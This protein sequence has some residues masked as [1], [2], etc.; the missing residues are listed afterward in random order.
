MDLE[1]KANEVK[2]LFQQ[3]GVHDKIYICVANVASL[4]TS[5]IHRKGAPGWS[6]NLVDSSG[7]PMLSLE[8]QARIEETVGSA[9]WIG[10]LLLK[11]GVQTGGAEGSLFEPSEASKALPLTGDDISLDRMFHGFIAKTQEI[12]EYWAKFGRD[13]GYI[14]KIY[15]REIPIKIG[16]YPPLILKSKSLVVLLVAL[17]DSIRV[18]LALSPFDTSLN[19]TVL[20]LLVA[21]EELATGQWRQCILTSLGLISPSGVAAGVVLKYM[22]NVWLLLNPDIRSDIILVSYKASKSLVVG[23]L[24]WAATVLPPVF[25]QKQTEE[26]LQK[27]RDLVAPMQKQI[28]DVKQKASQL[29]EPQ[30]L[31][32][33]VKGV[34]AE[35]LANISVDDIQILQQL[36]QN[37]VLVCSKEAC[38]IIDKIGKDPI[39]RLVVELCG[40]PIVKEDR[41]EVCGSEACVKSA[42]DLAAAALTPTVVGSG[43]LGLTGVAQAAQQ[44]VQGATQAAQQTVQDAT[45]AA[46]QTVQ[47]AK[48]ITRIGSSVGGSRRRRTRRASHV[49]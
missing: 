7:T 22:V 35:G 41:F 9:P 3:A 43:E 28:D 23:A 16:Q 8:E 15:E 4:I 18:S 14:K 24:L 11:K 20:T 30:G 44:T 40:V 38:D 49:R 29:L 13:S 12:D 45:Q 2:T 26:G 34:G 17:V 47:G 1:A 31:Q 37:P 6:A 39:F 48:N 25:I 10:D 19:R 36:A 27:L 33:S 32:V 5:Y 46:Q 21:I 42:G